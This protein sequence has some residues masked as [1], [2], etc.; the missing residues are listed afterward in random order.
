MGEQFANDASTTLSAAITTVDATVIHVV[1]AALFP[2]AAAYRVLIDEELLLVT[3]GAGTT[4]WTVT[5]GV[6]GTTAATH[7]LDAAVVHVL[8][9]AALVNAVIDRAC[10]VGAEPASPY[11]GKL[12]LE[13]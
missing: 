7:L 2:A 12:W 6:E 11:V 10:Q 4:D 13:E 1:S 3:A 9:A 5:R 8:T